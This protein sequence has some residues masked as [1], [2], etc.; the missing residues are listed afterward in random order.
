M[1]PAQLRQALT[2]TADFLDDVP[3]YAQGMGQV[4]VP[5]AW[6]L[7]RQVARQVAGASLAP[8]EYEVS[9]PVCTP[10]SGFLAAPGAGPAYTTGAPPPR[11]GTR[12]GRR[13]R[14]RSRSRAPPDPTAPGCTG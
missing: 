4:D 2:S 10:L 11:G 3:A 6:R 12:P 13:A 5:G 8:Q 9:A 14:T 1:T 7:L